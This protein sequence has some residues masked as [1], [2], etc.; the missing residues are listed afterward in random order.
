MWY[1]MILQD[2]HSDSDNEDLA[3]EDHED[4]DEEDLL[5]QSEKLKRQM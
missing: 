3:L 1:Y 2:E 5:Q 4:N